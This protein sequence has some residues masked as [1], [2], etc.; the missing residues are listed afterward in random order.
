MIKFFKSR[1]FFCLFILLISGIDVT[2][3]YIFGYPTK[4][5]A[6]VVVFLS[7]TIAYI[8]A[9]ISFIYTEKDREKSDKLENFLEI[10][11]GTLKYNHI[12][13]FFSDQVFGTFLITLMLVYGRKLFEITGNIIL[14][15]VFS[16]ILFVIT[17]TIIT[18]SLGKISLQ[19]FHSK[20]SDIKQWILVIIFVAITCWFFTAGIELAPK[21][22][23]SLQQNFLSK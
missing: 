8:A 15:A 10:P 14:S 3:Y 11:R 6:F 13:T 16:G 21:I 1:P 12:M 23:P 9:L 5:T 22:S 17:M 4:I 2:L 18:L 20:I 7:V 19:I